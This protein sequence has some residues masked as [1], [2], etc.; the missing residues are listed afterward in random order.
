M[1]NKYGDN[2]RTEMT[3]KSNR[4]KGKGKEKEKKKKT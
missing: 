3:K 4:E 1:F 2:V